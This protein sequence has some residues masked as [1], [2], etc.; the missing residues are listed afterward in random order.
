MTEKIIDSLHV[1]KKV[2]LT[3]LY[4]FRMSQDMKQTIFHI[5]KEKDLELSDVLRKFI[6]TII[7]EA[8]ENQTPY[9]DV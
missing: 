8:I 4:Q 2:K 6:S 9:D 5:L 7:Q 3:E 1:N